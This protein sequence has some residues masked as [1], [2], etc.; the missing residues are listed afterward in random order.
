MAD[1]ACN[2]DRPVYPTERDLG[3]DHGRQ[4]KPAYQLDATITKTVEFESG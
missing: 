3:Y 4:L 1:E 2:E